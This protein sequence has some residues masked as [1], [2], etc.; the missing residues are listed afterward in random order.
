MPFPEDIYTP[1]TQTN[2]ALTPNSRNRVSFI[3][4]SQEYV[5]WFDNNA[6]MNNIQRPPPDPVTGETPV[7]RFLTGRALR[8][9]Q[10]V[11]GNLAATATYGGSNSAVRFTGKMF[12]RNYPFYYNIGTPRAGNVY[13]NPVEVGSG[14]PYDLYV[15]Y[16]PLSKPQGSNSCF[17]DTESDPN[18]GESFDGSNCVGIIA[19]RQKVFKSGGGVLNIEARQCLGLVGDTINVGVNRQFSTTIIP[20][21]AATGISFSSNNFVPPKTLYYPIWGSTSNAIYSFGGSILHAM[22]WDAWPDPLTVFIP[23]YFAVMHFNPGVIGSISNSIV[24][25]NVDFEEQNAAIGTLVNENFRGG[26]SV[27][28]SLRGLMVTGG[29]RYFKKTI[30]VDNSSSSIEVKGKGYIIGDSIYNESYKIGI[31]VTQVDEEGGIVGYVISQEESTGAT[32]DG[33]D[34]PSGPFVSK[35]GIVVGFPSSS[36]Q[37]TA[38][39]KWTKAIVSSKLKIL[40]GPKQRC[41]LTRL[42][43]DSNGSEGRVEQTKITQLNLDNNS[44]DAPEPGQYE[45]FYFFHSDIAANPRSPGVDYQFHPMR[46][47]TLTIS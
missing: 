7:A 11:A 38:F 21:G 10:D 27:N 34:L 12:E 31:T 25:K 22:A 3:P 32:L 18:Y 47:V 35:S 9:F 46:H 19:A 4:I 40:N 24:Y 37:Q 14:I 39:I 5:G 6:V 2:W 29:L 42:T 1:V 43:N 30:S 45:V 20:G 15:D 41:R 16:Q 17:T 36:S 33:E 8:S 44:L 26:T 28:T 13:S 23:Q